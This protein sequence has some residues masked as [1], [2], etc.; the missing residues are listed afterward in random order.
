MERKDLSNYDISFVNSID[1]YGFEIV[2]R[3]VLC[4]LFGE[5]EESTMVKA[6]WLSYWPTLFLLRE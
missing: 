1:R 2:A 3:Q 6:V 5:L 4:L